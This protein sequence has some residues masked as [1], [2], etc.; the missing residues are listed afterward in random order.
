M[1]CN[2]ANAI[3]IL[4]HEGASSGA[5]RGQKDFGHDFGPRGAPGAPGAKMR[6]QDQ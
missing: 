6:R 3:G 5:K 2:Q 1:S 4:N